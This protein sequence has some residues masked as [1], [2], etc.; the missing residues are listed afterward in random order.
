MCRAAN[1]DVR[2]VISLVKI[3]EI[4]PFVCSPLKLRMF[5]TH[6]KKIGHFAPTILYCWL[7][8]G[9]PISNSIA[10]STAQYVARLTLDPRI[11]SFKLISA[12]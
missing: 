4:P 7:H 8:Y 10:L 11:A 6:K 1:R 12:T 3:V 2:K 9:F 5:M